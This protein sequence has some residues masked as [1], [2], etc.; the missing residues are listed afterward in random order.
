MVDSGGDGGGG[1]GGDDGDRDGDGEIEKKDGILPEWLNFITDDAKIVFV[2]V[3]VSLAF[4]SFIVEPRFIP[5]L[6]MTF[7]VGQHCFSKKRTI[8][9][10]SFSLF[11]FMIYNEVLWE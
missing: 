1:G 10:T 7:D 2:V 6:S 5:S 4:R 3:V 9:M 8:N 11:P